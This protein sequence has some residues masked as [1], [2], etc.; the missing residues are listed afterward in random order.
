VVARFWAATRGRPYKKRVIL[1]EN[2]KVIIQL[3]LKIQAKSPRPL[4]EDPQGLKGLGG[5]GDCYV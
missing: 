3:I 2:W 4:R 1:N 5:G